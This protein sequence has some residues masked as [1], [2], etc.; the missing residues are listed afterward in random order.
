MLKYCLLLGHFKNV[1]LIKQYVNPPLED[2]LVDSSGI[3]I[4]Y[5]ATDPRPNGIPLI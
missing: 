5:T 2:G 1:N 3:S 4:T